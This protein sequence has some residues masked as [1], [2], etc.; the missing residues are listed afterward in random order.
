M[1]GKYLMKD[2]FKKNAANILTFARF[3]VAVFILVLYFCGAENW[4]WRCLAIFVLGCITDVAD[5]MVARRFGCVSDIGKILDPFCDKAMMLSMLLVLAL[6][7]KIYLWV[8]IALA[9]KEA[10]MII[11]SLFFIGKKIVVMANWYGKS[12]T[13]L[14]S[15]SVVLAVC[16]LRPY[17]DWALAVSVVWTF[18]A[19][20]Q[21]AILYYKQLKGKNE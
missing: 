20:V 11:G 7:G 16:G 14:F 5:G 2:F 8:F 15:I 19:M 4:F 10:L 9:A 17:S 3:I 18:V 13:V 1:K 21:Y 12:A 6:G